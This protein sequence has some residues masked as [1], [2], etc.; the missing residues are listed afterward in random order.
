MQSG[1]PWH[2]RIFDKMNIINIITNTHSCSIKS[3][4]TRYGDT[5]YSPGFHCARFQQVMGPGLQ[6]RDQDSQLCSY[7][8]L[9]SLSYLERQSRSQWHHGS[10][11]RAGTT[12]P[13]QD[14]STPLLS[15]Q[16]T[17]TVCEELPPDSGHY[18]DGGDHTIFGE[19]DTRLSYRQSRSDD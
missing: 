2:T 11:E 12:W 15:V 18:Q 17:R 1:T 4:D 3:V 6:W 19:V 10:D 13:A 5:I 16:A 7:L 8:V 14:Q 9:T